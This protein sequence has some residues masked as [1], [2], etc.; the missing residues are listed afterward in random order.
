MIKN[1]NILKGVFD[2][3]IERNSSMTE[4]QVEENK[5][6]GYSILVMPQKNI[7]KFY[8]HLCKH[9][10]E[11]WKNYGFQWKRRTTEL[12]NDSSFVQI[13]PYVI[14]RNEFDK[15]AVFQ[16][17]KGGEK[18]LEGR[19]LIGVGGHV[20]EQDC[21]LGNGDLVTILYD[22]IKRELTEE[23]VI[24]EEFINHIDTKI[25]DLF[26]F[27]LV[28]WEHDYIYLQ[29]TSVNS[30]HLGIPI[31]I[32]MYGEYEIKVNGDE[33]VFLGWKTLEEIKIMTNVEDW[34]KY[35]L[36]LTI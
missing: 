32:P 28:H 30:V 13:I 24:D 27:I 17:N 7:K 10:L 3:I 16:R 1:F 15:Y 35:V 34:T 9:K 26:D 33:L 8:K 31:Y 14:F 21:F 12:E 29:N 22:N 11:D 5:D 20:E 4:K 18:R 23:L 36:G 6:Y 25:P 2:N 19:A